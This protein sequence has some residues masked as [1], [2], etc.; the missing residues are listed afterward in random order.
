M[1]KSERPAVGARVLDRARPPRDVDAAVH[2][3]LAV[4]FLMSLLAFGMPEAADTFDA[5]PEGLSDDGVVPSA[6]TLRALDRLGGPGGRPLSGLIG[7]ARRDPAADVPAFLGR[8]ADVEA[9]EVWAMLAGA[10]APPIVDAAG[11]ETFTAAA[12]GDP[13]ARASLVRVL[14]ADA[15]DEAD[16]DDGASALMRLDAGAAKALVLEGLGGW[17]REVFERR[18]EATAEPLARDAAEKASLV[19]TVSLE[20]LVELAT[21]G[22]ELRAEPWVRRVVLV[23]HVSMRPWNVMSADGSDM[24]VCYPI[25]DESLDGDVSS[26]PPQIVRFH[27]ALGDEK[28]LRILKRLVSREPATLQD[29]A[30]AAGLAKST[31]HHHL[32]I[33]R[34]AGLVKVMLEEQSR[35]RLDRDA[36]EPNLRLLERFL[37]GAR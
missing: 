1:M 3:S 5:R 24:I 19:G 9:E 21:H 18:A 7:P 28:R 16:G 22:L 11:A 35:F 34:A 14:S 23:P 36:L 29:L 2:A 8:L 37:E 13:S 6:P 32:V 30:D 17:Y 31:A 27:R 26:P 15:G 10:C 33:L 12:A 4:E 20:R 25:A